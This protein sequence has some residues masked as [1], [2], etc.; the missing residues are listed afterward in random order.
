MKIT[1]EHSDKADFVLNVS[2]NGKLAEEVAPGKT[3]AYVGH[4]QVAIA[5]GAKYEPAATAPPKDAA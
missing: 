3:R 2:L 4:F 1:V 5:P